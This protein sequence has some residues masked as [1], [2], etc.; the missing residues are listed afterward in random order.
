MALVHAPAELYDKVQ[1]SA[2]FTLREGPK[3]IGFGQVLKRRKEGETEG[4]IGDT[5]EQ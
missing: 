1:P 5:R 3:I 2:T 4:R